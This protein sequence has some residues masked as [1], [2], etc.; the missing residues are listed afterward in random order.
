M[1]GIITEVRTFKTTTRDLLALSE[2]L[3]NQKCTHIVTE[4]PASTG[5]RFGTFWFGW[6]GPTTHSPPGSAVTGPIAAF[7]PPKRRQGVTPGG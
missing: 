5:S 6:R 3:A 4:G 1:N 7:T 2:W